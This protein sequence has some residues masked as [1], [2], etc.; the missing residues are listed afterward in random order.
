VK[1]VIN[2]RQVD[3]IHP[4]A[5]LVAVTE[6]IGQ[7]AGGTIT[8]IDAR[9]SRAVSQTE[10]LNG[11]PGKVIFSTSGGMIGVIVAESNI[12][13]FDSV[14]NPLHWPQSDEFGNVA[15][16]EQFKIS[17]SDSVF[18]IRRLTI[19]DFRNYAG[20]PTWE[21]YNDYSPLILRGSATDSQGKNKE[22]VDTLIFAS[23][24]GAFFS[25]HPRDGTLLIDDSSLFRVPVEEVVNEVFQ[26]QSGRLRGASVDG[27]DV[28]IWSVSGERPMS[29]STWKRLRLDDSTDGETVISAACRIVTRGLTHEQRSEYS[30]P[31]PTFP[32]LVQTQSPNDE[33]SERLPKVSV[34][35][36]PPP[37]SADIMLALLDLGTT[38]M[39]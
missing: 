20:R 25:G 13:L 38:S 14:G 22:I 31:D 26:G 18:Q 8:L 2:K 16:L 12:D 27:G 30:L 36:P 9:T 19:T 37:C 21:T 34:S 3:A 32:K 6:T 11:S 28:V 23:Q 24:S 7:A 39:P 1:W 5:P 15:F 33:D 35:Y 17:S 29:D 4:I 10:Q